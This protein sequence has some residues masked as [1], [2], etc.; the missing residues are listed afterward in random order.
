MEDEDE[1]EMSQ[2]SSIQ[3]LKSQQIVMENF[4]LFRKNQSNLNNMAAAAFS[5]SGIFYLN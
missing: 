3:Q 4:E 2:N 1:Q 5:N